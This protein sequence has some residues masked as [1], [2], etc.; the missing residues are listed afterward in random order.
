V[1]WC[2]VVF[3]AKDGRQHSHLVEAGTKFEA[4]KARDD[5]ARMWWYDPAQVLLVRPLGPTAEYRLPR[6]R[7]G[8]GRNPLVTGV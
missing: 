3:F 8:P 6:L 2:E 7:S 5:V 1:P 4:S